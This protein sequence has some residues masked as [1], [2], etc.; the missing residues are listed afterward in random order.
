MQIDR[1]IERMEQARNATEFSQIM[2]DL[3]PGSGNIWKNKLTKP[4]TPK[5]TGLYVDDTYI[6]HRTSN[7]YGNLQV[8]NTYEPMIINQDHSKIVK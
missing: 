8:S 7:N 5:L 4:K 3:K 2:E 6:E 1:H